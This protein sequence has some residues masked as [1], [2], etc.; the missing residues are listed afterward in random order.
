MHYSKNDNVVEMYDPVNS[1]NN[2]QQMKYVG[3]HKLH[4]IAQPNHFKQN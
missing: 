1:F 2:C 3:R 4:F